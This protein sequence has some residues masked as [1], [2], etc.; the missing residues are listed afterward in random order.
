MGNGY[1]PKSLLPAAVTLGASVTNQQVGEECGLS[2]GGAIRLRVDLKVSAVTAGAGIT[3]K[4]QQKSLDAWSDLASTNA[5]V[6]ITTAGEVSIKLLV[7][8][9][10]D[11]ADMPLKKQVRVVLTTGAGSAVTVDKIVLLQPL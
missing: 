10:A 1:S 2:A 9:S 7:E 3:A 4:L 6:A 8:R 11:Q 5:S